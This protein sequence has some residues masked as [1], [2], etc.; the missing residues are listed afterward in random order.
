MKANTN[1][2]TIRMKM[3]S[4]SGSNNTVVAP[5]IEAAENQGCKGYAPGSPSRE[6]RRNEKHG[7]R[8]EPGE[9]PD[10]VQS[11]SEK[12]GYGGEGERK[13][14]DADLTARTAIRAAGI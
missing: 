7:Q 6:A 3:L 9:P 5:C 10:G 11:G 12:E 8:G 1:E 13:N 14:G 4:Q 2:G